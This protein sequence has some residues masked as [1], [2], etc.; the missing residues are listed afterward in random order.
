MIENTNRPHWDY[1][2]ALEND[3]STITRYIEFHPN[4]FNVYSIELTHLLFAA[5]AESEVVMKQMATV[6]RPDKVP[7]D[8]KECWSMLISHI[9]DIKGM[10]ILMPRY[11]LAFEPWNDW[12]AMKNAE[13][14]WEVLT[15]WD[16]YNSVKH[17][18]HENYDKGNLKNALNCLAALYSLQLFYH[19]L[20]V[21]KIEVGAIV[22]AGE[23]LFFNLDLVRFLKPKASLFTVQGELAAREMD[24]GKNPFL[25]SRQ[26]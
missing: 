7:F 13:K 15:W 24:E 5:A 2:L 3:L 1:F 10:Q 25:Y 9:P 20:L 16:A 8:F 11:N 6:L 21:K 22:K 23:F 26:W 17:K 12:M 4:N 18:R 19:H 14:D